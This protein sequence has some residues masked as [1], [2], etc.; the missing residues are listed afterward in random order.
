MARLDTYIALRSTVSTFPSTCVS[1]GSGESK[2]K[3]KS[4]HSECL[5]NW[6]IS[7]ATQFFFY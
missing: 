1:M 4:F 6:D 5:N 7:L 3:F 2:L